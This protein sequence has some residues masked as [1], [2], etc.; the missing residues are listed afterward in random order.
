MSKNLALIN[1]T[2]QTQMLK[3][4]NY[5]SLKKKKDLEMWVWLEFSTSKHS[6]RYKHNVYP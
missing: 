6:M 5:S 3:I 4:K 2:V 1:S